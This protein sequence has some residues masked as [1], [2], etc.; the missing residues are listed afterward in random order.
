MVKESFFKHL[1]D[2]I[3]SVCDIALLLSHIQP[4]P[5]AL[6]W[7]TKSSRGKVVKQQEKK[8]LLFCWRKLKQKRPKGNFFYL[9]A[10]LP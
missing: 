1:Q 8:F 2:V 3:T 5:F 9:P 10:Y 7:R 6:N 4:C